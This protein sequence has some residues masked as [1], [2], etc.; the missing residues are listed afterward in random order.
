MIDQKRFTSTGEKTF[1]IKV[2]M[3]GVDDCAKVHTNDD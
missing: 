1:E 2:S 3:R